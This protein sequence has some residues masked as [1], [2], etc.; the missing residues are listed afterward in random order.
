MNN[1]RRNW[2]ER[3]CEAAAVMTDEVGFARIARKF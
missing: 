2:L 1:E 3:A